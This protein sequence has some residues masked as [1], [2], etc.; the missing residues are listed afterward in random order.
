MLLEQPTYVEATRPRI[1]PLNV[2]HGFQE[3]EGELV[4]RV[5]GRTGTVI[6]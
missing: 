5:G 3:G 4:G 6:L 1:F 2:E